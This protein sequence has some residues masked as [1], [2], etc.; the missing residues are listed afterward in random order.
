MAMRNLNDHTPRPSRVTA[1]YAD[2]ARSFR[3]KE[4]ATFSDLAEC[5]AQIEARNGRK[6][7]AIDV[8]FDAL[9]A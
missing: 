5:L 1:L 4:G 9:S 3:L 8:K 2:D 6:P 7:I